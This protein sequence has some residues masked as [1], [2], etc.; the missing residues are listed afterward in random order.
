MWRTRSRV[1]L[2]AEQIERLEDVGVHV[3]ERQRRRTHGRRRTHDLHRAEQIDGLRLE[4]TTRL[5]D[6]SSRCRRR[7]VVCVRCGLAGSSRGQRSD[8]EWRVV[9]KVR[10]ALRLGVEL[11]GMPRLVRVATG[12]RHRN[13]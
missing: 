10:V 7:I 9:L 4:W 13:R 3:V 5:N 12:R 1:A 6:H 11:R 2:I 8:E